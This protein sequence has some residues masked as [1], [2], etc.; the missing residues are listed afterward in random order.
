MRILVIQYYLAKPEG[1]FILCVVRLT[2]ARCPEYLS[3][4]KIP[5]HR[6]RFMNCAKEMPLN[7]QQTHVCDHSAQ[8]SIAS[9]KWFSDLVAEQR[10]L[11]GC[12]L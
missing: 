1:N 4:R 11:S 8:N 12:C 6:Q 7:K 10:T 9:H 5:P 3:A 2:I